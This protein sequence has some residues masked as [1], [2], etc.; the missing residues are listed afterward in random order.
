MKR[1]CPKCA[2][3]KVKIQKDDGGVN[4]KHAEV[5]GR[6]LHTMLT[7]S[8]GV[9]SGTDF[10]EMGEENELHGISFTSRAG[11]RK[12]LRDTHRWPCITPPGGQCP[13]PV[14]SSTFSRRCN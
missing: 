4:D 5:T 3:E 9:P 10:S 1:D 8:A 6:Q 12:T 2:E 11:E 7:S 13:S 14:S